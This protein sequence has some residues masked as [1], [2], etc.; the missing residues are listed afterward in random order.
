[1]TRFWEQSQDSSLFSGEWAIQQG[2]S[3]RKI[4]G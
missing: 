4:Y 1:M 2:G 3:E